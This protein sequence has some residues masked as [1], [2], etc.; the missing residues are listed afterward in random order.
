L[1]E[2]YLRDHHGGSTAGLALARRCRRANEG[3][4][5]SD[6][7][8]EIEAEIA[9][10]KTALESIMAG[11]GATPSPVKS[12][13]G[14]IGERIGR[15]KRNGRWTGYSPLSRVIELEGLAAGIETKR[16]LW[17]ALARLDGSDFDAA[18]LEALADRA[19]SQ[20]ERVRR[21]HDRAAAVTFAG[22]RVSASHAS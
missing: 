10:D 16:N 17:R 19:G 1:L 11:L 5:W 14:A 15:L 6:V 13:L 9:E 22:H 20:L 21:A 18:R 2:I 8:A 7:L 12:A 3:S 4:E